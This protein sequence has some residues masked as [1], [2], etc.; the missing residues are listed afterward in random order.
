MGYRT[1]TTA[2]YSNLRRQHNIMALVGNGFDIQVTRRY[3][4]RFSPRY[5]AF[6]YYLLSRDF[7]SSNLVVQ[8]MAA[9]KEA[10]QQ[11]WSNVE[12]AIGRLIT[13][14]GGW[15]STDA[16]YEAT[17]AIQAAFSEYL[18]LVAPPAL[19]ARVGEDSAKG[20]WAMKSM[21]DVIGDVANDSR[22]VASF[23]FPRETGH[24]DLF[25][26]LFVNFNYTPLLDDYVFRD[27]QQFRPQDYKYAD[28]NFTFHPNPTN[29]PSGGLRRPRD[30][31]V[32]LRPQRGHSSP[33]TPADSTIAPVRHGRPRQFRPGPRPSSSAHEALLGHEPH[34]VRTPVSRY[35]AVHHLRVL[36]R[37]IGRLVVAAH[38]RGAESSG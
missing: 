1:F 12:A 34:G 32:Q 25:N 37:R 14:E 4:S 31:L 13:P 30:R 16:V 33:R 19:L 15:H 2:E 7:D 27:A 5:P 17:R 22:T 3:E 8:Q 29:Q 26:Y 18:E 38:L 35:S 23:N 36:P 20:S 21:A 24:Y 28:R 6:Y 9:A 10:G 11:N